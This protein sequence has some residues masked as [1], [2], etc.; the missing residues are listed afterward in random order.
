M[1]GEDRTG[2]VRRPAPPQDRPTDDHT[3]AAHDTRLARQA[4]HDALAEIR[5]RPYRHTV[6]IGAL[7]LR[8]G[9]RRGIRYA[10][11]ELWPHLTAAGR[12]AAQTLVATA[13]AA[14]SD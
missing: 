3:S 5:R 13:E 4:A 12:T 7:H 1:I 2:A 11:R 6:G 9:T 10:C 8:D 14:A